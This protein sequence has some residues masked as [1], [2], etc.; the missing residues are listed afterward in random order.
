MN[1]LWPVQQSIFSALS[2]VPATYPVYDAVPQTSTGLPVPKPY[3][4][5]G[6][7]TAEPDEELAAATTD[8]SGN[9]HAW[10]AGAGKK[11]VHAM[12]EFARARLDGQTISGAWACSEDFNEVLEDPGSTAA[13]RIY[14]G[15]ARYR[16][17][18]G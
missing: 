16:L 15:V 4:V 8:A 1:N 11:E 3:F 14:H 10:S 6:E 5:I 2:G 12:L 18:V 7:F 17:R 13:A 9:L